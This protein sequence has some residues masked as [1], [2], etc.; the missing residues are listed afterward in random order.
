MSSSHSRSRPKSD[1]ATP[2]DAPQDHAPQDHATPERPRAISRHIQPLGPRVLVRIIKAPDRSEHGLYLPQGAKDAQSDAL[3]AE[4]VEVARTLPKHDDLHGERDD[5][6]DGDEDDE[7][8]ARTALGE[9][10]SGIPLGARI[11]FEKDRGTVV[12]WDDTLR[13]VEVRYVLAI[14]EIITEDKLQ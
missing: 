11:L 4:V 2:E 8:Y 12:P 13:I 14:V 7:D 6:D 3:L 1:D 10:V 5:P 9:N